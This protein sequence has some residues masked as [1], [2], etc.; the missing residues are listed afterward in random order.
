MN[1]L[2]KISVVLG[3]I[4]SSCSGGDLPE[5]AKTVEFK[6]WGNCGMCKKTIE[7]SLAS[8]DNFFKYD[9]NQKTK[10]MN[11]SFDSTKTNV[12]EAQKLIA[13]VGYDTEAFRGDD[14]A[15]SGLHKCC[16]YK[17]KEN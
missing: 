14:E 8:Q 3:V 12:A 5:T 9:W 10:I 16:K 7:S 2:I 6:V 1:Y 4:L 15:Y 11:L 13:S 17:R